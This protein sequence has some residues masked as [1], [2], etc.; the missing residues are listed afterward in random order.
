MFSMKDVKVQRIPCRA[1][2]NP[3]TSP[4]NINFINVFC[5]PFSLAKQNVAKKRRSDEKMRKKR[6]RK[7][8]VKSTPL[9]PISSLLAQ[10]PKVQKDS[11]FKSFLAFVIRTCKS[12]S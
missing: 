4:P 2:K 12:F 7:T 11:Q 3:L 1:K 6:A 10:I 9:V 5:A 8:L